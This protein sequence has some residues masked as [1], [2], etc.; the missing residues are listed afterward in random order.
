MG[1]QSES[2]LRFRRRSV[3][4]FVFL[5]ASRQMQNPIA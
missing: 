4:A 2:L 5:A 1:H 3:L